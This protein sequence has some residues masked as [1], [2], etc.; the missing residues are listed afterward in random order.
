MREVDLIV[1]KGKTEPVSVY[2]ILDFHTDESF[3]NLPEV[4]GHFKAA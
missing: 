1:V 4:V 2:E 3:P